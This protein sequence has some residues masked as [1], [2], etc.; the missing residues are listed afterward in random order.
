VPHFPGWVERGDTKKRDGA[1][2]AYRNQVDAQ[3][4]KSVTAAD[5]A[6]LKALSLQVQ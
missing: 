6:R 2:E 4:G 5:A 3:A 1:L